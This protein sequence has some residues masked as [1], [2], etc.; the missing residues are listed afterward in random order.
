MTDL[1]AYGVVR[2]ARG[3]LCLVDDGY[4]TYMGE[5]MAASDEAR[6][7]PVTPI[8]DRDGLPVVRTVGD[9]TA[10]HIGKRVRLYGVEAT[11]RAI[12][13][14]DDP[15][16][17]WVEYADGTMPD[18]FPNMTPANGGSRVALDAPVEVLP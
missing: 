12:K 8:L 9:L 2:G 16:E 17:V 3:H 5:P 18:L 13:N 10:R 11:L 14:A 15:D 7:L 6:S 1:T 4:L